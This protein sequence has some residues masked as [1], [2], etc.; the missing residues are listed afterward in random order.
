M[1]VPKKLSI[2]F[3]V[4]YLATI[5][6][7]F[8]FLTV[9]V[10]Q[11]AIIQSRR[12]IALLTEGT[13]YFLAILISFLICLIGNASVGFPVPYPF[14]LFSFSNSIYS[15]YVSQGLVIGEILLN[16]YFWLEILGIT[17][18]GGLGSALGELVSLLIG[19]GAKKIAKKTT[20]NETLRNVQGFGRIILEYPKTMYLYIFIAAALPIPDD[21]LWIALGMSEKRINFHKCLIF[22]WMGKNLTT[23]FYA[24]LPILILFGVNATGVEIGDTSSVITEAVLLLVTIT[25]MYFIMTFDWLKLL[26]K[27]KER[28]LKKEGAEN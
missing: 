17:L 23:L 11:D 7:L 8:L 10:V 19:K 14:I 4:F 13:N 12:N 5:I 22:A 24:L 6:Y 18:A 27:R 20:A 15:N 9:P 2:V 3:I 25:L 28:K 21:P 16:G 26:E 1:A